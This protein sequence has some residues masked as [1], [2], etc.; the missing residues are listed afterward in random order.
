MV[1]SLPKALLFVYDVDLFV[2]RF[3]GKAI[4]RHVQPVPLFAFNDK[5]FRS[6]SPGVYFPL[7]AITSTKSGESNVT[8][9]SGSA[10]MLFDSNSRFKLPERA[11]RRHVPA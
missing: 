7:C 4:D 6:V 1:A 10:K 2:K 5:F 8:F 11:G 3:A 9:P